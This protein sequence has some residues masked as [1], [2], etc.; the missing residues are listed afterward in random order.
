[1][2]IIILLILMHIAGDFLFQGSMLSS[3]K[4]SKMTYL[5]THV[6]IYTLVFILL[7]P[8]LLKLTFMQGLQYSLINGVAHLLVDFFTSKFK[9]K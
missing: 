6:G 5:F 8:V 9:L 2:S 1:M 7:S 3:R 4:A